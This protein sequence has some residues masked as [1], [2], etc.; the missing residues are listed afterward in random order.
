MIGIFQLPSEELTRR[1]V[2]ASESWS[3][4]LSLLL[5]LEELKEKV[6][7]TPLGS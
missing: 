5:R 7:L 4:S 1:E 3:L 2:L 6:R